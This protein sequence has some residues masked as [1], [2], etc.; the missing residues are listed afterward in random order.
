MPFCWR[1]LQSARHHSKCSQILAL[2]TLLAAPTDIWH[3]NLVFQIGKL[4]ALLSDLLKITWANKWQTQD[5]K[6]G[7]WPQSC[8]P[9]HPPTQGG[10]S[11]M[12]PPPICSH[13]LP[14]ILMPERY[15]I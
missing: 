6:A 14:S 11:Q 4:E 7:S 8:T 9:N 3:S 2:L 12:T 5:Q 13:L 1:H 10:V 15:Q